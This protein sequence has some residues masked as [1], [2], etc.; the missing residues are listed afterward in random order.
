MRNPHLTMHPLYS[1]LESVFHQSKTQFILFL[2]KRKTIDFMIL[3]LIQIYI[4]S[5]SFLTVRWHLKTLWLS[6]INWKIK[7]FFTTC[8][9]DR[10][11]ICRPALC[12]GLDHRVFVGAGQ[13]R[14]IPH[15]RD[16]PLFSLRRHEH[17]KSHFAPGCIGRMAINTLNA[18]EWFFG[19]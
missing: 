4:V 8:R 6:L 14:Q 5:K 18:A 15:H 13:A 9:L 10:S 12:A 11:I 1:A 7:M 19:G 16:R 17:R 3:T 2:M